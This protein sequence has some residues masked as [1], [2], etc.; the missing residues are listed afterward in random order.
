MSSDEA[1]PNGAFTKHMLIILMIYVAQ[2]GID[3]QRD[4]VCRCSPVL[5]L[6]VFVGHFPDVCIGCNGKLCEQ[7]H[8][9]EGLIGID[10]IDAGETTFFKNFISTVNEDPAAFIGVFVLQPAGC[11]KELQGDDVK[12]VDRAF[13]FQKT[14]QPLP[15]HSFVLEMGGQGRGGHLFQIAALIYGDTTA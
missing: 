2:E 1:S 5:W 4:S 7:T 9:D 8:K 3:R 13:A 10:G 11:N 6:L 14:L 12:T 15:A